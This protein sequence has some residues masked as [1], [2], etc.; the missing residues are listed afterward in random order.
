VGRV[1]PIKQLLVG[2]CLA[3]VLAVAVAAGLVLAANGQGLPAP[4][5]GPPT[6]TTTVAPLA[7][8]SVTPAN[9]ATNVSPEA[10]V[11]VHT[12]APVD[13]SAGDPEIS[14]TVPGVWSQPQPGLLVFQPGAPLPPDIRLVLTL[15]PFDHSAGTGRVRA[16]DG[17]SLVA[18]VQVSWTVAPGSILRLQEI[19]AQLGYLPFNFQTPTP[20]AADPEAQLVAAYSPPLG[21]FSWRWPNPPAALASQWT[22]G[23]DTEA[24]RGAV[25]AFEADAGLGPDGVA[26]PLVWS[27]LLKAAVS[28][29]P[30]AAGYSYV[31]VSKSLPEHL[32]LWHNGVTSLTTLVNT[33]VAGADTPQ[34]TWPIYA[35]Y[36]STTM[37]GTDP[38]GTHYSDPGVPWVNYFLNGDAIHGFPRAQ[39]GF[40]QSNGCVELP[41]A[42]AQTAYGLLHVGDLVT[43]GP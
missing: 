17:A 13:L 35:R 15:S 30:T 8:E 19:L 38:D 20:V 11:V 25:M 1:Q 2:A 26:G 34:G 43:V 22:P 27:A 29:S 10:P 7:V 39:Y 31:Q 6:T 16:T 36:Q 37:T 41:V 12:S 4:K 5:A 23:Q 33:G 18:P 28:G 24:T 14:P 40:P 42:A 32:V 21:S 3:V 9:G